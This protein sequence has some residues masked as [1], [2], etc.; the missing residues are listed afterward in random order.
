MKRRRAYR[1]IRRVVLYLRV[2]S[3][4]QVLGHSLDSQS[5]ALI[6]WAAS[7]GWEVVAIYS[8]AGVS[9]TSVE[10]RVEFQRMIAAGQAGTFDAIL[11]LKF[12]RFARSLRDSTIYREL[13]RDLG[14][15][16]LSRMEPNVGDDTSTGF[17]MNG[18]ADLYAAYYSIALSENVTRGKAT[19]AAKGLPLGDLPFGYVS[20]GAQEPPE[21][22][23]A[24][25]DQVR[26]CFREYAAGNRSM[27]ELAASL[28]LAG[29]HPRSKRGRA[30]FSKATLS[31]MLSNPTYVGDIT[32]YGQVVG[33]GRHYAIIDRELWDAVQRA[34]A[35][36]ARKP[37]I[38]GARPKRPY[39]LSGIGS[40]A[41][42][43][44]PL[45]AN[46]ISGGAHNYYRC[47][48]RQRGDTCLDGRVGLRAE[49]VEAHIHKLFSHVTLPGAWRSRVAEL[50]RTDAMRVDVN[51]E[52]K[53]LNAKLARIRQ[54]LIDG[55]LENDE[56]KT[57]MRD[58]EAALAALRPQN[59]EAVEAGQV[60]TDVRELW[61][62]MT[63]TERRDL[64]RL[65]LD[66]VSVDLRTGDIKAMTPKPA[67]GCLFAV[68]GDEEDGLIRVCDWRPR[69][70]SNPRSPP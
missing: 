59:A 24:E 23:S 29:F 33:P 54:G 12:D 63:D 62:R 47:A 32:R 61:P 11:V 4:E 13:L 65:V 49:S 64:V 31:G 36:R 45:W 15:R 9:G 57:A 51:A 5:T 58:V 35:E 17:L 25:A 68:L 7:E 38:Y 3:D 69:R 53:H 67:F 46:T 21:I 42:C 60:L 39:L 52:R 20:I 19:R 50:A 55:V 34:R 43:G 6:A 44:A 2:S 16:L 30:V 40:C 48:S 18:Q 66:G 8:D 14:I 1:D 70:D 26:R 56:A 22:V 41:T 27:A 37:Q 28:T 10:R